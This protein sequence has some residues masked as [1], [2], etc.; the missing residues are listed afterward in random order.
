MMERKG[1]CMLTED[2]LRFMERAQVGFAASSDGEG[3]PHLAAG[4]VVTPLD[5]DHLALED[6]F[7]HTTLAN[8][9]R[10]PRI[11]VV[12]AEPDTGNGYQFLGTVE[13]VTDRAMI[14]GLAPE[15]EGA[16]MPQVLSRIVVRIEKV[17]AFSAGVH[18]DIP[19]DR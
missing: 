2:I 3:N 7:C 9:A 16:G 15:E 18:T 17:F 13:Q 14:D 4:R 6:W 8:I 19:L 12:V 11:A 1:V 10:N 5:G